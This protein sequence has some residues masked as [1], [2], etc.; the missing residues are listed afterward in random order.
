MS[1]EIT[2]CLHDWNV[3]G[4][5]FFADA[6]V[7]VLHADASSASGDPLHLLDVEFSGVCAHVLE[8]VQHQNVLFELVEL[9]EA[10]FVARWEDLPRSLRSALTDSFSDLA[11]GPDETW[12]ARHRQRCFELSSSYGMH[13]IVVAADVRVTPRERRYVRAS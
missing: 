6:E 1:T 11:R 2:P 3:Y 10:E 7:L 5:E 13:G 4:L 8:R 9:D 12:L